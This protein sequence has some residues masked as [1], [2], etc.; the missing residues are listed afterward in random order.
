MK[1]QKLYLVGIIAI[2]IFPIFLVVGINKTSAAT[3]LGCAER[4][5]DDDCG[6]VVT[7]Q[8]LLFCES[9]E[10]CMA[11]PLDVSAL[12]GAYS[13]AV[14][15][16]DIG[17]RH[18]REDSCSGIT[19]NDGDSCVVVKGKGGFFGGCDENDK[20]YG[21]WSS[22]RCIACSGINTENGIWGDDIG[23]YADIAKGGD[24]MCEANGCGASTECD[25]KIPTW[26]NPDGSGS[27]DNNCQWT[28]AAV[29]NNDGTCAGAETTAN[30]PNDCCDKG[31]GEGCTNE[32]DCKTIEPDCDTVCVDPACI[33]DTDCGYW[34]CDSGAGYIAEDCVGGG[35]EDCSDIDGDN[36]G[37]G[38]VW[39]CAGS[40]NMMCN[41]QWFPGGCFPIP[42]DP[43]TPPCVDKYDA[44]DC[45]CEFVACTADGGGCG[46]DGDCCSG[47][48]SGGVCVAA[49]VS[50]ITCTT[51]ACA[52]IDATSAEGTETCVD[53]AGC[54]ANTINVTACC[55]K[56]EHC[57]GGTPVCDTVAQQCVQCIVDAD[58]AGTDICN[59]GICQGCA[60]EGEDPGDAALCCV[61]LSYLDLDGDGSFFCTSVCDPNAWYFCNPLRGTV[62]TVVEAG[63]TL[64]GFILGLIGSIALLFIIIAGIMYMTSAGNEERISSSKRILSGAV[65]GLMIALL[66]Y[67]LLHVIMTVLGM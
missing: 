54:V 52:E 63:E 46:G 32:D 33:T 37:G 67:G 53:A 60:E 30:C 19:A 66:A 61:G 13:R 24:S 16:C 10:W 18:C 21:V 2:I 57:S 49:C 26:V 56:D 48:C 6:I 58:C 47:D 34:V 42:P 65:I 31:C 14:N 12:T 55:L 5:L 4:P 15:S 7:D 45:S 59:D 9:T 1:I 64:L 11:I 43:P 23:V 44:C 20:E 25:E 41:P 28:A 50:N 38:K 36:C 62:E 3:F 8:S 17:T 39:S 29:C 40:C 51:S 35:F 27:C 22:G